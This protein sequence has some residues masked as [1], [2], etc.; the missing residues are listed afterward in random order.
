MSLT[1]RVVIEIAD[2]H[3]PVRLVKTVLWDKAEVFDVEI[4]YLPHAVV[5]N[6]LDQRNANAVFSAVRAAVDLANGVVR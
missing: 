2:T 6:C 4:G 5:I 3:P 1:K